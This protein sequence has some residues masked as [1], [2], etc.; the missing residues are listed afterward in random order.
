MIF[1]VIILQSK[2]MIDPF[3]I[4]PKI[5]DSKLPSSNSVDDQLSD[6]GA[7]PSNS[8]MSDISKTK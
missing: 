3:E 7:I 4:H 2:F 1:T 6:K 8:F 5:L